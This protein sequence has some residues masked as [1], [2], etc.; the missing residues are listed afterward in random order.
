MLY[1]KSI[2]RGHSED[3]ALSRSE[4]GRII[5]LNVNRRGPEGEKRSLAGATTESVAVK[6]DGS[7]ARLQTSVANLSDNGDR[8]RVIIA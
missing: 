4:R 7:S 8:D 1:C 2:Y 6:A 5:N 3:G